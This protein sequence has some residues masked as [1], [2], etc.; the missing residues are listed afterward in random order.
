MKN[1]LIFR[2]FILVSLIVES[3]VKGDGKHF[4]TGGIQAD[5]MYRECFIWFPVIKR[6]Q[7][8]FNG[9]FQFFDSNYVF[10]L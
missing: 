5:V 8:G 10:L 7:E 9:S 6:G 1:V 2:E 4:L 3:I